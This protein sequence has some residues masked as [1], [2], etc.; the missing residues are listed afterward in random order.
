MAIEMLENS[1]MSA[2]APSRMGMK[3]F[4]DDKPMKGKKMRN[5]EANFMN[6]SGAR[7][8][9]VARVSG[10]WASLPQDC[11]SIDQSIAI[12]EADTAAQI[13]KS[14]AQKGY[15]LKSTKL[16]IEQNQA[17][18]GELKKVKATNCAG[19]EEKKIAME[20]KA[21]EQKLVELSEQSVAKAKGEAESVASKVKTNKNVLLI[22]GG[23]VVL[24][25]IAYFIFKKK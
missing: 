9:L 22:G 18:L 14:A 21:F 1:E 13:K 10:Q 16:I 4:V 7:K 3:N 24:G 12:I 15:N 2:L 5:I 6:L 17:A 23:V 8:K 20:E 25:I 19:L 11:N